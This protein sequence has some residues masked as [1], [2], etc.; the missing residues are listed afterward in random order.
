MAG[1]GVFLS[2]TSEKNLDLLQPKIRERIKAA[3]NEIESEPVPVQK[4]DVTKISGSESN[5][6]IRIGHYRIL[7]SVNWAMREIK[8]FDIDRR[9]D[10]TYK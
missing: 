3:L 5:Y 8:V 10:S 6:R 2:R 9:G 4:Y 1:F 7:Y